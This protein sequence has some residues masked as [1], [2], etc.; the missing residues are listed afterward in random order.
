MCAHSSVQAGGQIGVRVRAY[1]CA[2]AHMRA[3]GCVHGHV[4]VVWVGHC[5]WVVGCGGVGV[6]VGVGIPKFQYGGLMWMN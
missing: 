1:A 6:G 5:G 2:C 4:R 3:R